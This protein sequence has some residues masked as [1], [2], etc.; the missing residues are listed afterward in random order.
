MKKRYLIAGAAYGLAG[1]TVAAKLMRRPRDVVWEEH[2]EQLHH[3]EHS[4]FVE[5]DGVRVHYQEAGERDAPPVVLIHGFCSSTFVW[6]DV[7]LPIAGMGFR[8]IAPDLV[9]F[10]FSGKPR[11]GEYTI[12][13]QARMIVRLLDELG[14]ERASLVGSSYGGAVAATC[15]LDAPER[16]G[17]LV[18]VGA[19]TND[20]AKKQLMLRLAATPLMG[21]LLSP[22]ILDSPRLMKWRMARVYANVSDHLF[23]KRRMAAHQLPLRAANT[24]RAVLATLRR[25][26]A[27]RIERE[28]ASITQPTLLIWGEGDRDI[29]LVY[30]ERLHARMPNAR[31]VV[32][33]NCGHLPQEEYPE[34]FTGLVG[35]FCKLVNRE[36]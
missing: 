1:A 6:S 13:A 36:S 34:E 2:R 24:H 30:G 16:V 9:G 3:A 27:T 29:P 19:V 15:A 23:E 14:V 26:N 8:V 5:F 22:L 20:A 12:E 32:F 28:A 11:D 21:D 33:R 25:W 31:L 17:R 4:R 35:G 10:G 18:L 7:L